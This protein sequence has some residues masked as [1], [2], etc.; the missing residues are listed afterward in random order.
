[1]KDGKRSDTT[2]ACRSFL[3]RNYF[4]NKQAKFAIIDHLINTYKWYISH[5]M[6]GIPPPSEFDVIL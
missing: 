6:N 5:L 1:M 3:K 2:W 4:F